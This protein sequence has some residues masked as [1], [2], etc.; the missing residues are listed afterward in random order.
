MES[1]SI[2]V[3]TWNYP[4]KRGGIENLTSNLCR[5]LSERYP[6]YIVTSGGAVSEPKQRLFRPRWPG[7]L[8]FFVFAVGYS[9][10]LLWNHREIKVILGG[11]A[12][13]APVVVILAW[14][15]R[16]RGVVNVHGLDLIY[17]SFLYQTLFVSWLRK[18]DQVVANSRHTASIVEKKKVK[19]GIISV[20]SPSVDC[21]TFTPASAD[22]VKRE[23]GL[24]GRKIILSVGRLTP[25]KGVKE[26][27]EQSFPQIVK[28]VPEVCFL[29]VGDNPKD[30]LINGGIDVMSEIRSLTQRIGV[31][32]QVRLLGDLSESQLVKLY[33]AADLVVLPALWIKEDTEGFGIVMIEGAASARPSVATRLGGIPDAVDDQKSGILVEPGDYPS[34][35]RSI[36]ELL[37]DPERRKILGEFARR[38]AE[39]KFS[40]NAVAQSYAELFETLS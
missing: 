39:E 15:F 28:E 16:R 20:I 26:F 23:L 6:V 34:I 22:E 5:G 17:P 36:I 3:I 21:N 7:L 19:K 2:L 24:E 40:I 32:N 27:V 31:E 38:R 10:H 13:V 11:S 8:P 37:G 30:A 29:I 35:S 33:Q 12:L 25:R 1:L 9:A 14:I 4:P 18:L